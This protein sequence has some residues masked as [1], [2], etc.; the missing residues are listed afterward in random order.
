M[1]N[2]VWKYTGIAMCGMVV[3]TASVYIAIVQYYKSNFAVNTWINGVYCTG[4]TVEEVNEELLLDAEAPIVTICGTDGEKV[5]ISLAE[6]DYK[7]DYISSL[8]SY[9]KEQNSFLWPRYIWKETRVKLLPT[10][11]FDEVKLTTLVF[12]SNVVQK[13]IRDEETIDVQIRYG[14]NGYEFY[15]GMQ[16]VFDAQGFAELA[17][18]N[19]RNGIYT[20]DVAS[21]GCFY[22]KEESEEQAKV[23]S[24]W[25][26]LEDFLTIDLVYDMGAE[27]I[28]FDKSLTSD[29]LLLT[30]SGEFL[31]D[32]E[33]NFLWDMEKADAFVEELV[34]QYNTCDTDL[35]FH[36]TSGKTVEVPYVTYG[37]EIDAE[38]EKEYLRNALLNRIEEVHVPA[39]LQEGYV[40]GLNDIG[41]TYI[42]VDMTNQKLYGY[43]EGSIVVETDIV[44]GNMR[45]NWDTPAGVNFVYKKQKNRVLRG[46]G[47]ASPVDFWMPVKG[48]IG[49]H[50]A[51]WRKEFGGEIYLR[52]GSHGCIN[53]PVDVMPIVYEEF[54][55]GTP[56]I[57]FYEENE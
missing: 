47:Y 48:A 50:D 39:Y 31:R 17:V 3:L 41:D 40:R 11:S 56:V 36:A 12:D 5:Q 43:K 42:E 57:M 38:A 53:V 35:T 7:E 14:E 52:S 29:L 23:R 34:K 45:R 32:S 16:D 8:Q 2:K 44:T 46:E 51:D 55:V 26:K 19:V 27:Q 15:D 10:C 30:D 20:T 37:T 13:E 25:Q 49:I 1:W 54:E 18:R 24:L 28:V 6:V 4:K 9:M 33:G 21:S 22:V